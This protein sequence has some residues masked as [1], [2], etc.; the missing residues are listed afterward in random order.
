[1]K[2]WRRRETKVSGLYKEEPG[3]QRRWEGNQVLGRKV[4]GWGR[5]CQVGTEECWENLEARPTLI[6]KICTPVPC[7]PYPPS[8][9]ETKQSVFVAQIF[10]KGGQSHQQK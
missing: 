9:L 5:V 7:P 2:R 4:Q 8:P 10:T 6:C 3:G 1:M